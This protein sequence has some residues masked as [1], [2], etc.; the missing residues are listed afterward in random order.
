MA[1]RHFPKKKNNSEDEHYVGSPA[2]PLNTS[3][4]MKQKIQRRAVEKLADNP[5]KLNNQDQKALVLDNS[6]LNETHHHALYEID[7]F[8]SLD[9]F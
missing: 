4:E 7:P 9:Y 5:D 2:F 6:P 8:A 3:N 1:P